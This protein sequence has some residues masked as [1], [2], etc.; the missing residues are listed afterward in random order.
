MERFWSHE[1]QKMFL[2]S[3]GPVWPCRKRDSKWQRLV[4][5]SLTL[6]LIQLRLA[7]EGRCE[8]LLRSIHDLITTP[9]KKKKTNKQRE[10]SPT[11]MCHVSL[12]NLCQYNWIHP[13][14]CFSI[15]FIFLYSLLISKGLWTLKSQPPLIWNATEC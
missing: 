5:L 3:S 6:F 2:E 13:F 14:M 4:S 11:G 10:M 1:F 15:F 12:I 9:H 7:L 8:L